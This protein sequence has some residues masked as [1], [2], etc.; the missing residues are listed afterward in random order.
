MM[1]MMMMMTHLRIFVCVSLPAHP[2]PGRCTA[3]WIAILGGWMRWRSGSASTKWKRSVPPPPPPPP[4]RPPGRPAAHPP[5]SSPPTHPHP[6]PPLA[7]DAFLAV[8]GI[9]YPDRFHAVRVAAFALEAVKAANSVAIYP[10]D[11]SKGFLSIRV[12]GCPLAC[13]VSAFPALY[14]LFKLFC[15][16]TSNFPAGGVP[17]AGCVHSD[18]PSL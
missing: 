5:S 16:R 15:V 18:T 9:P 3:S 1:M 13:A 11:E 6:L 10:A 4:T 7:G 8:A 2:S 14:P 12:R 17:S